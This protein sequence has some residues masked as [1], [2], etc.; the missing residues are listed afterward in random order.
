MIP[1]SINVLSHLLS[2][3]QSTVK[4]F[5]AHEPSTLS[6]DRTASYV[7]YSEDANE[8]QLQTIVDLI[9]PIAG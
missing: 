5:L 7:F 3:K 6:S 2:N 1:T 9:I 4:I 8:G